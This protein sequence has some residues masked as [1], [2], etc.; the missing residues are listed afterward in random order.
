MSIDPTAIGKFVAFGY[1]FSTHIEDDTIDPTFWIQPPS[2]LAP[3]G[4]QVV[5]PAGIEQV[6]VGVEPTLVLGDPLW[7]A[8]RAA[9]ADAVAGVTV[10]IDV[11][12][13]D[14][15]PAPVSDP[16][17]VDL[18]PPAQVYKFS[19][20]F[21]PLLTEPAPI[22]GEDL[23]NRSVETLVDGDL[24]GAGSTADLRFDPLAL[25]AEVSRYVP[26][27]RGDLVALGEGESPV[28]EAP[29]TVTARIEGVGELSTRIETV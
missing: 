4:D 15:L 28:V 16:T 10:S 24:V 27:E 20:S 3:D 12:A 19:P 8:S 21:R 26:L 1:T 5:L 18:E 6:H 29:G 13:P 2:S 14:A 9:V 11:S 23:G 22:G 25:V 17:D 7:R